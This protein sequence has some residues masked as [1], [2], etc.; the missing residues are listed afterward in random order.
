MLEHL[1]EH[2]LVL[3]NVGEDLLRV[4]NHE[5]LEQV[6]PVAEQHRVQLLLALSDKAQKSLQQTILVALPFA[7]GCSGIG[8]LNDRRISVAIAVLPGELERRLFALIV[9]ET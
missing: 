3:I 6:A 9:V 8:Y 5:G 7:R 1:V 2:V 4:R